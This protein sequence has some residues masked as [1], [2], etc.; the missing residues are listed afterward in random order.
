MEQRFRETV[1]C[2]AQIA[3][4]K[5]DQGLVTSTQSAV[6]CLLE[7]FIKFLIRTYINPDGTV[8]GL[9]LRMDAMCYYLEDKTQRNG[10][11]CTDPWIGGTGRYYA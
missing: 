10:T 2:G 3:G 9:L 7:C 5:P 4:A 1:I 8:F 11:F 6:P